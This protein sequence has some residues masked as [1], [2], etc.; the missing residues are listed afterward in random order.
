[1]G[2]FRC[3]R[4][5]TCI[6]HTKKELIIIIT[7]TAVFGFFQGTLTNVEQEDE[8]TVQ[9]GYQKRGTGLTNELEF[10]VVARDGTASKFCYICEITLCYHML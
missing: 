5:S 3:S 1:M 4:I 10:L 7:S 8:Y 2:R 9:V 6:Q